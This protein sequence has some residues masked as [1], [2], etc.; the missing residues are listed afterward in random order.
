M[1]VPKAEQFATLLRHARLTAGISQQVLAA[2]LKVE[3]SSISTWERGHHPAARQ[4][5]KL[6]KFLRITADDLAR[7]LMEERK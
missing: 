6:A 7:K 1:R 2:R 5:P 3:A 4:I